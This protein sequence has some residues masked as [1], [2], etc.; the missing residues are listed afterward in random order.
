MAMS[1]KWDLIQRLLHEV[2]GSAND[3]FK[4]RRYAEEHAAQLESEGKSMPNLDS[5]RAEA[6]DYESL[7]FEGG[8]IASRPEEQGGNGENFVLTERGSRLLG[9]LDSPAEQDRRQR[10][11]EKGEA[12]LVPEVF[13]ELAAGV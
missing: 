1:Y 7:L 3:T 5:L 6:A 12:A 10:L 11:A 9:I 8:F 2:Q 13:D 4:P